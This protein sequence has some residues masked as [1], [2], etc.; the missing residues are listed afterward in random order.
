MFLF[1]QIWTCLL[2]PSI[3]LLL[4][5]I[6]SKPQTPNFLILF[7][8]D[9]GYGDPSY[10]NHPTISTPNIDKL[11]F[12]GIRFTQWYSAFHV[13]SPSRAAMLTGRL[14]VRSGMAGPW[15]GGVL[16]A[17]AVGGLPD[18]ETTFAQILKKVGYMTKAIGKWHLG[19][20]YKYL[21]YFRGF[22]EYF[23]IPY[24]VDMGN[25]P[26]H[27]Q[28][29]DVLPL[30][31]NTSIIEQPVDLSKLSEKYAQHAID[32]ISNATQQGT[33][34]QYIYCIFSIFYFF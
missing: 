4:T 32:F 20:R 33:F 10:T 2:L 8:D 28:G 11:A 9:M 13:C 19:Q 27:P 16:S 14:P 17:D 26:W 22:D 21:P 1:L 3:S 34:V 23:G 24:S 12:E 30:I 7:A 6:E 25:T 18:N 31:D 5:T 29:T 15:T